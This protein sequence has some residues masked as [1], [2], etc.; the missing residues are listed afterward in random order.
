MIDRYSPLAYAIGNY[1]HW[2]L[3]KH[4]GP[5][6][7]SRISLENVHIM[8]GASLYREIGENCIKCRIKR[9]K[10]LE[11]PMGL[12]SDHQLKICPPFWIAQVDLF[13]PVK[14][15]VPGF[16]RKTRNR[17]VVEAKVWV[18]VFACPV[19]RL[20]N[21]QVVEKSDS[22]GILDGLV[23]LSCETGVPKLLMID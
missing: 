9:K 22:A 7:C 11:V 10:F 12:I 23:R 18:L 14:V 17:Q 21:L 2:N 3:A 20:I 6:T 1:V 13:G 5:E 19:T 15:F 8:Q 16:E 4:R